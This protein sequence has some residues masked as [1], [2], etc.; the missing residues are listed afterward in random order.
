MAL[1]EK[2]TSPAGKI[3]YR[4]HKRKTQIELELTDAEL[5]SLVAGL[6]ICCLHAFE[7]HLPEHKMISRK[8]RALEVAI[9]DTA[10]LRRDDLSEKHLDAITHAWGAALERLHTELSQ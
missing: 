10:A 3:T 5:C 7:A 9:G 4:E 2:H 1:Y 6:G 8:V